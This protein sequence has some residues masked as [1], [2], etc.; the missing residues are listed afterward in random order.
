MLKTKGTQTH[1]E[2]HLAGYSQDWLLPPVQIDSNPGCCLYVSVLSFR[3][4]HDAQTI[5]G[6]H[7]QKFA[8]GLASYFSDVVTSTNKL[9]KQRSQITLS[10]K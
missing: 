1:K 9:D 5:D 6:K 8:Q 3:L 10:S 4:Q 7:K 2:N